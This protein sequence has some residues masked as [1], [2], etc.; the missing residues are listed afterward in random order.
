MLEWSCVTK[1]YVINLQKEMH[2]I[3]RMDNQTKRYFCDFHE[4]VNLN[5]LNL[6]S[7]CTFL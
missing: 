3:H 2:K 6:G 4:L 7:D 5:S 1:Y